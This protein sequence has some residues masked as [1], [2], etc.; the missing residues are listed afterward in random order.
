[1]KIIFIFLLF[2][3][4]CWYRDLKAASDFLIQE[5]ELIPRTSSINKSMRKALLYSR[6][7]FVRKVKLWEEIHG[8]KMYMDDLLS[9]FFVEI[10]KKKGVITYKMISKSI[11]ESEDLEKKTKREII[12]TPIIWHHALDALN[13]IIGYGDYFKRR[14][15]VLFVLQG[16]LECARIGDKRAKHTL[17]FLFWRA[18]VH[19]IHL[20][21]EDGFYNH[22]FLN[23]KLNYVKE[24][25]EENGEIKLAPGLV[26]D[27]PE[28]KKPN[29]LVRGINWLRDIPPPP[30]LPV[31]DLPHTSED[32]VWRYAHEVEGIGFSVFMHLCPYLRSECVP[33]EAYGLSREVIEEETYRN[34]IRPFVQ[35]PYHLDAGVFDRRNSS[36]SVMGEAAAPSSSSSA[37]PTDGLGSIS[38]SSAAAAVAGTGESRED[39]SEG[40]ARRTGAARSSAEEEMV[41]EEKHPLLKKINPII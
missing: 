13:T 4:S 29:I 31:P 26:S 8:R 6:D 12:I 39:P 36:S 32:A 7:R 30:P 19:T 27:A 11:F 40:I 38:A 16:F 28:R 33:F 41:A 1:M 15:D 24:I 20:L 37:G 17:D 2:G 34:L 10:G 5:S 18:S 35:P 23:P 3:I 21:P 14:Y 9:P 22:D 25:Y